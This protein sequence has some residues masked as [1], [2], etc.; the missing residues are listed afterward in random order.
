M[1]KYSLIIPCYN[2]LPYIKTCITSILSQKYTDYELILSEDHSS[3]GTAEYLD[4]LKEVN[5]VKIL[6]CPQ[7][8]SMAEHWEWAQSFA[9]GEWQLFIGQDDGI[10]GYFFELADR[11]TAICDK[12]KLEVIMS[13]RAYFFWPGCEETYGNVMLNYHSEDYYKIL[14]TRKEMRR[15]LY[16]TALSYMDLPSMYTTSLFKKTLIDEIKQKQNGK[17]FS[18]HPQDA[19]LAALVVLFQK[20]YIKSY[21]PL[22]WVGSSVK[23]A[24]LA[25]TNLVKND[26]NAYGREY[27]N[28]V[29]SSKL[30][31]HHLAG[32]FKLPSF[33]IYFWSALLTVSEKQNPKLY[34]EL[35]SFKTKKR[36]FFRALQNI[37]KESKEMFNELLKINNMTIEDLKLSHN[38]FFEKIQNKYNAKIDSIN[39]RFHKL[40]FMKSTDLY[41]EHNEIEYDMSKIYDTLSYYILH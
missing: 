10:Q 39:K 28:T 38:I 30:K 6:H 36:I 19:N 27:L 14:D 2:G 16:D 35:I 23:S 33:H 41:F 26:Q 5:N 13:E 20:K 15:A 8:M 29:T 7:R 4:S 34:N 3:D 1:P 37:S 9:T 31:T 40:N 18:T 17:F 24:G 25:I 11:L 12:K 21:I 22:G 32:D